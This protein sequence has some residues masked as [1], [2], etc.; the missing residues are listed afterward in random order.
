M[1]DWLGPPHLVEI[2]QQYQ[3]LYTKTCWGVLPWLG[4]PPRGWQQNPKH[5]I[6]WNK[7]NHF[8]HWALHEHCTTIVQVWRS[9]LYFLNGY[10]GKKT[11]SQP[12]TRQPHKPY[13]IIFGTEHHLYILQ[14][15][16]CFQ[17]SVIISWWTMAV[18]VRHSKP[19]D[20]KWS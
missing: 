20:W 14:H 4:A 2:K 8:W 12:M 19:R 7:F 3:T 17:D 11:Y 15:Q 5:L 6:M 13:S 18:R 16:Q 1:K 10:G 9:Y